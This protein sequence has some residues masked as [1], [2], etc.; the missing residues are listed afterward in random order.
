MI[1]AVSSSFVYCFVWRV[2]FVNTVFQ[3][4]GYQTNRDCIRTISCSNVIF[5]ALRSE[6][7]VTALRRAFINNHPLSLDLNS[8][9]KKFKNRLNTHSLAACNFHE[10]HKIYCANAC[11][12]CHNRIN[13]SYRVMF[14]YT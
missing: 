6:R 11:T 9:K 7:Y 8:G 5:D 12:S 13:R 1:L 14:R 3:E 4:T 10:R 2:A